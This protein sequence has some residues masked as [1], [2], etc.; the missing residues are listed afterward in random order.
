MNIIY[1]I[2]GLLLLAIIIFGSQL[3][4]AAARIYWHRYHRGESCYE[5]AHYLY[6]LIRY[7]RM[8]PYDYTDLRRDRLKVYLRLYVTKKYPGTEHENA[9][10]KQMLN[11]W[12]LLKEQKTA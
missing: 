10:Q 4:E 5:Q 1:P 9:M 11:K 3:N 7:Y 6:V 8:F 2:I 12:Y